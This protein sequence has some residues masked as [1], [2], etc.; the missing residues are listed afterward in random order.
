MAPYEPDSGLP[1]LLAHAAQTAPEHISLI[2]AETG[3][4]VTAGEL[5]RSS[6]DWCAR[7]RALGAAPGDTVATMVGNT[8]DS[9]R[10]WAGAALAGVVEVPVSPD[11]RGAAL[12]HVFSEAR[13]DVLIVDDAGWA[14][15]QRDPALF[16]DVRTVV[17]IA[18]PAAPPVDVGRAVVPVADI[19]VQDVRYDVAGY[20][21]PGIDD[22]AMV[23]FTS[24]T[25]GPA[26]G[27]LVS[28]G[29][30]LSTSI[31]SFPA[32]GATAA[33]RI[34]S[35]FPSNHVSARVL[36]YV[37]LMRGGSCVLRE[38]FSA[39]N[40]WPD[41][42]RF[43]CTTTALATTMAAILLLAPPSAD[44]AHHPLRNVMIA[45]LMQD[46]P[47]FAQR[48]DARVC[49]L[50]TMTEVSTPLVSGWGPDV[51]SSCGRVRRGFPHYELRL[52]DEQDRE[53]PDGEIGELTC[54]AQTRS[55]LNLG[56]LH[57]P[58]ETEHAWRGGW[59]H[60][61]DL[62]RRDAEGRFYFA[63]RLKDAIRHRGENVSAFEVEREV[64]DIADIASCAAV[65]V[66][67][68]LSEE[69]IYLYLVGADG[70]AVDA[71]A[72]LAALAPRLARHMM[73][74]FVEVV[75]ELPLTATGKVHKAALR[76]A[77]CRKV[78]ERAVVAAR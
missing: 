2:Q 28:W 32:D 58:E 27:V 74:R 73:P 51:W 59:F 21:L 49:T 18:A 45:P 29:Q 8:I 46:W 34:Y 44:D 71:E 13:A 9:F 50:F 10:I 77:A 22:V 6:C 30:I 11:L 15:V 7:L 42:D 47:A 39:N 60:T 38:R 57:L 37:A 43:G 4:Q 54:R 62:F 48:F 69:D 20:A 61:G 26:K 17:P 16:G 3:E 1:N 75:T 33:D 35:A 76:E 40:F 5:W 41:V 31:G 14:A 24:G 53:V 64:L 63:G 52:V 23:L 68:E 67:S 65:G 19:A 70:I 12:Q 72:V 55:A 56:Y 25:T 78:S 66:P 36:P